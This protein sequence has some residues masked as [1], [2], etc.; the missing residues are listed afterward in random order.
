MLPY[1]VKI[2]KRRSNFTLY[3]GREFAG[4][5]ASKWQ[6]P[7]HEYQWGRRVCI[8]RYEE[9]IR[10]S[11]LMKYIPEL[12]DQALGC[13]CYPQDCHGDVL[14]RIYKEQVKPGIGDMAQAV[15]MHSDLILPEPLEIVSIMG[16]E[17]FGQ[18]SRRW[19]QFRGQLGYIPEEQVIWP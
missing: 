4:L 17:G 10:G 2:N 5:P 18:P 16:Q 11:H 13:W 14:V 19:V 7:F 15:N 9:Y 3:I 12:S 6:N 8:E 1:V